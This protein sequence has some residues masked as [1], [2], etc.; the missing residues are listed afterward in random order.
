MI[1]FKNDID[2][3]AP[4]LAYLFNLSISQGVFPTVHKTGRIVPLYK[5]KETNE[6]KNYRPI[7]LLNAISKILEKVVSSR[8]VKH[9]EEN[10][11]LSR[12]QYAY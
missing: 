2:A 7:C 9:L 1:I 8:L 5:S 12:H 4:V 10:N 11:I 6:I 3:L